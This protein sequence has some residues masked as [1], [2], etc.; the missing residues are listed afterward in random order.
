V[1]KKEPKKE[2]PPLKVKKEEFDRVL[3]KLIQTPPVPRKESNS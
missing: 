1:P 3:G 2:N